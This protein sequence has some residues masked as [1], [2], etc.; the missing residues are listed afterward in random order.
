MSGYDP[1]RRVLR[2]SRLTVASLM[3]VVVFLALLPDAL[4]FAEDRGWHGP[5]FGWTQPEI[6]VDDLTQEQRDEFRED[7][8]LGVVEGVSEP[9][10]GFGR[11][12]IVIT[13]LA[14]GFYRGGMVR[15]MK[16]GEGD[17]LALS[18]WQP[19]QP[20]PFRRP[21][22]TVDDGVALAILTLLAWRLELPLALP[23][24]VMG[25]TYAGLVFRE[26]DDGRIWHRVN[27][28]LTGVAIIVG[29]LVSGPPMLSELPFAVALIP[30]ALLVG[31]ALRR[32]NRHLDDF[33]TGRLR[34]LKA[35]DQLWH[36]PKRADVISRHASLDGPTPAM[37][38]IKTPTAVS[39][40][41]FL[42]ALSLSLTLS[43][44]FFVEVDS[45][46][47]E[48]VGNLTSLV[49]GFGLVLAVVFAATGFSVSDV[50][51]SV[52]TRPR[53]Q[54]GGW[55]MSMPRLAL[56]LAMPVAVMAAIFLAG[57]HWGV[58]PELYLPA[59]TAL[60]MT[61]IFFGLPTHRRWAFTGRAFFRGRAISRDR[62]SQTAIL[63]AAVRGEKPPIVIG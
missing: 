37:P 10:T 5:L 36:D 4:A 20:L 22:V 46:D 31:L 60:L 47:D 17:F 42:T 25:L 9:A 54:L 48:N 35:R 55:W 23:A 8:A 39:L 45:P 32:A 11:F 13:A 3:L 58:W 63:E 50:W 7:W 24:L 27:I 51:M 33:A 15:P 49:H 18:P 2:K 53:T 34:E 30:T 19:S 6:G 57:R 14:I 1:R 52:V 44:R 21:R 26:A 61:W 41:C 38:H 43:F 29:I 56:L 62:T 40:I 59:T 16:P 12:A 28:W